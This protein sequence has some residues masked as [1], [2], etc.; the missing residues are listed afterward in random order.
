MNR[1]NILIMI[2]LASISLVIVGVWL[3]KNTAKQVGYG[4][5]QSS[6]PDFTFD[7]TETIDMTRLK[8][9]GLPIIIDFGSS[10][11]VPCK[12][13]YEV[14]LELNRELQG[15]AIIRYVDTGKFKDI[16]AE[17]PIRVL[18]TQIFIGADGK[19]FM[20]E[21]PLFTQNMV[22]SMRSSIEHEFTIHEGALTKGQLTGILQEMGIE[23]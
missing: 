22:F 8:S 15:K 2:V 4:G 23:Q 7:I 9:Y 6:N 17:F 19:A 20:S 3:I 18:P 12:E 21:S 16:T 10:T 5:D 14:I 1:K 11:C 13:L